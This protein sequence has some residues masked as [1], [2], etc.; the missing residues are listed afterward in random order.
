MSLP[1]KN[2]NSEE[3]TA[4]VTSP[5]LRALQAFQEVAAVGGNP[6]AQGEVLRTAV[7]RFLDILGEKAGGICL[8][9]EDKSAWQIFSPVSE[10]VLQMLFCNA[11]GR[12]FFAKAVS[13]PGVSTL[14]GTKDFSILGGCHS[15][16]ASPVRSPE[17]VFGVIVV[18]STKERGLPIED[19]NLLET[20]GYFLGTCLQ[21]S[22][23]VSRSQG[24][25]LPYRALLENVDEIL[26]ELD[27]SGCFTSLSGKVFDSI[28]Y[29]PEEL[30]GS[31]FQQ[32]IHSEDLG[33]P[34]TAFQ[35]CLKGRS[36]KTSGFYRVKHKDGD[37]RWHFS[38][39][40]PLKDETG[41]TIGAMGIARDVT[42]EVDT[43]GKLKISE[44]RLK[45]IFEAIPESVV[46]TDT[47]G[48][49]VDINRVA[50]EFLGLKPEESEEQSIYD[51]I[52]PEDADKIEET[53]NAVLKRGRIS[54]LEL[55]LIAEEGT[56]LPLEM[57]I[58]L[59][60]SEFGQPLGFL[61]VGRPLSEERGSQTS[62]EELEVKLRQSEEKLQELER[63]S[64]E[65]KEKLQ[66]SEKKLQEWEARSRESEPKLEESSK[67]LR[68]LGGELEQS[69]AKL[70]QTEERLQESEG[71]LRKWEEKSEESERSLQQWEEKD[72]ESEEKLR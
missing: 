58:S 42:A 46:V 47:K 34:Q 64:Q 52:S 66:D 48:K 33:V 56:K 25:E 5:L 57:N 9:G 41:K 35:D 7:G 11:E 10:G 16:I 30:L 8:L 23:L 26:F 36:T 49:I 53:K 67:R 59:L 62:S 13:R 24:S 39:Y 40:A 50:L 28:G 72:R 43:Q 15:L 6:A 32:I 14:T 12:K 44:T 63:E 68:E 61:W 4:S 22:E 17:Q 37:Y 20:V 71:R 60:E 51:F 70:R 1:E 38:S 27:T 65:S 54:D 3:G 2:S 45:E 18:L 19:E 69:E 55:T 31:G 29:E 21:N